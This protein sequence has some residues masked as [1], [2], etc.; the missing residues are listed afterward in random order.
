MKEMRSLME[1]FKRGLKEEATTI[2]DIINHIENNTEYTV[3]K[4]SDS[5]YKIDIYPPDF[6]DG[7][8]FKDLKNGKVY[9]DAHLEEP[10]T[11][12]YDQFISMLDTG[13]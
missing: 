1:G 4:I 9:V 7:V 6:P 8:D 3:K 11:I 12:T 2:D 13:G 5:K 10:V